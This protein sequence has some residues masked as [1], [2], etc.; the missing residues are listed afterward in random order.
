ME[1][2]K[3]MLEERIQYADEMAQEMSHDTASAEKWLAVSS[4]LSSV[5]EEVKLIKFY[6]EE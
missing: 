4:E 2:V 5:L 3:K 1:K 6:G